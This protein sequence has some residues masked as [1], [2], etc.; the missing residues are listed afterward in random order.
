MYA[1]LP[2]HGLVEYNL[3]LFS[4]KPLD[5]IQ[6]WDSSVVYLYT[7]GQGNG[8]IVSASCP[9]VLQLRGRKYPLWKSPIDIWLLLLLLLNTASFK[10]SSLV[11]SVVR[12]DERMFSHFSAVVIYRS[13]FPSCSRPVVGTRTTNVLWKR[14]RR[15]WSPCRSPCRDVLILPLILLLKHVHALQHGSSV[16]LLMMNPDVFFIPLLTFG[17]NFKEKNNTFC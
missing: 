2:L 15:C 5:R 10:D 9:S 14:W 1:W 12:F 7:R 16:R 3:L 11:S 8:L 13:S 17:W 6:K 4:W